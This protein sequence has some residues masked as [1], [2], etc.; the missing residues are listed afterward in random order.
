MAS[1]VDY[2]AEQPRSTAW[3]F[4]SF[5]GVALSL[6]AIGAYGVVSWSMA[7][8]TLEIGVRIALGAPRRSVFRLV[9]GQSLRLVVCGLVVGV[10]ASFALASL[11]HHI[12][13]CVH[14]GPQ[15]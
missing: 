8:R 12:V 1:L 7:Q 13:R 11:Q 5:A 3:L 15:I 10:A 4:A 9:L 14:A 6:A 2:S